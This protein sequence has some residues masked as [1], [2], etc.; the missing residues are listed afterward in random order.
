MSNK[1]ISKPQPLVGSTVVGERGQIVIPKEFRD[2]LGLETGETLI[3][4][5]H[6]QG[7]IFLF[8]ADQMKEFIKGMSES[9]TSVL[10]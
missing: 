8:P 1:N 3:V 5:Y 2:K 10:K 6:G 4:M 9:I 7:P